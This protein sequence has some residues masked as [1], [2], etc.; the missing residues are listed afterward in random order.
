MFRMLP[1]CCVWGPRRQDRPLN[2]CLQAHAWHRTTCKVFLSSVLFCRGFLFP[3]SRMERTTPSDKTS[4]V[5]HRDSL[6]HFFVRLQLHFVTEALD[7][8][9]SADLQADR[10]WLPLKSYSTQTWGCA[11]QEVADVDA[12]YQ[13]CLAMND[14]SE[15]VAALKVDRR[16][17]R[18]SA[19]EAL[20][21][22]RAAV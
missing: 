6:G 2:K 8:K 15:G 22:A 3:E 20:K 21:K 10:P 14:L 17:H 13:L 12:K 5:R 19:Y 9:K 1:Q 11:K 18:T 4:A 16:P 7:G